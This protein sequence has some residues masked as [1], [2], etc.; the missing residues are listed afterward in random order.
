MRKL[1]FAEYTDLNQAKF[2][3]AK[4]IRTF[5]KICIDTYNGTLQNQS[6]TDA[7]T[8]IRTKLEKLQDFP[9]TQLIIRLNVH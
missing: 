6:V 7:N 1:L 3:D 8:V 9:R 5:T 4:D 2:K